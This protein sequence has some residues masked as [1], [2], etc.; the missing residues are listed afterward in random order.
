M[1]FML[2]FK[3]P[4]GRI[5][6]GGR[7]SI[8]RARPWESFPDLDRIEPRTTRK[9]NRCAMA[10]TPLGIAAMVATGSLCLYL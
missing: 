4:V 7:L 2:P 5:V 6:A 9:S 10:K 1:F 8:R 3:A